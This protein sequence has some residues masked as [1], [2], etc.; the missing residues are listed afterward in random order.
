[1]CSSMDV[2]G[3]A[4][5][6]AATHVGR[7]A[8]T[9]SWDWVPRQQQQRHRCTWLP[10]AVLKAHCLRDSGTAVQEFMVF[11]ICRPIY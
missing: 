6:L 9:V 3:V 4:V 5:G 2:S 7:G 8:R 11:C 1:M 10:G